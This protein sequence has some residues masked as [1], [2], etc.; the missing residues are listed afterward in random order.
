MRLLFEKK[1]WSSSIFLFITSDMLSKWS[2]NM[3][4]MSF[5]PRKK[6]NEFIRTRQKL[7][8]L[9][10]DSVFEEKGIEMHR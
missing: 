4:L 10:S 7:K 8:D 9:A 1:R 2:Q 3:K 6:I 5:E